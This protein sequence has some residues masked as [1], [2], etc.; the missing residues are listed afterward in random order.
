MERSEN[1]TR[2]AAIVAGHKAQLALA[3]SYCGLEIGVSIS[4]RTLEVVRRVEAAKVLHAGGLM[5][6]EDFENIIIGI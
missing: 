5:S 3:D 4:D 1:D 2:A 6:D